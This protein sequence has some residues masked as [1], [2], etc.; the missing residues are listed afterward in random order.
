MLFSGL[1]VNICLDVGP[2]SGGVF[3]DLNGF[4]WNR[5]LGSLASLN[6]LTT[7]KLEG[8][9]GGTDAAVL[10]LASLPTLEQLLLSS[11]SLGAEGV[12]KIAICSTA[13]HVT[14]LNLRGV[15]VCRFTLATLHPH[16]KH[17]C[18]RK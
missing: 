15:K 12:V 3:V 11:H 8:E 18:G 17:N 10:A 5:P 9:F 2:K 13:A 1:S 7:L 6:S 16:L 4:S 14:K